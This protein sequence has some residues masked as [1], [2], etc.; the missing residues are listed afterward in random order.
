M[1]PGIYTSFNKKQVYKKLHSH[2]NFN[3][4]VKKLIMA[5]FRYRSLSM[6]GTWKS[7]KKREK[8]KNTS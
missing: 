2:V 6:D 1:L 8:E 3:W 4:E 5:S 7:G